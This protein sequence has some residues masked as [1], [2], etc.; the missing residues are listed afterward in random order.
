MLASVSAFVTGAQQAGQLVQARGGGSGGLNGLTRQRFDVER[1]RRTERPDI[2][3]APSIGG[4][5][6]RNA[7]AASHRQASAIEKSALTCCT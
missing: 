7:L 3:W 6:G 5:L 1:A 2:H 4:R